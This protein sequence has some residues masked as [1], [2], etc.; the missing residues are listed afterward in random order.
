MESGCIDPYFLKLSTSWRWVVSFTPRPLY[1]RGR[2]PRYP[3]DKR[4]GGPQSRSGRRGDPARGQS[5][6]W[7][8]YPG[9]HN[10]LQYEIILHFVHRL[11]FCV[12]IFLMLYRLYRINRLVLAMETWSAFCATFRH[13]SLRVK[14]LR[15][16]SGIVWHNYL[17]SGEF[18]L[19]EE[20]CASFSTGTT[21]PLHTGNLGVGCPPVTITSEFFADDPKTRAILV[22]WTE[23]VNVQCRGIRNVQFV[24]LCH[25]KWEFLAKFCK[26]MFHWLCSL[27][28]FWRLKLAREC[29]GKEPDVRVRNAKLFIKKLFQFTVLFRVDSDCV[30]IN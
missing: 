1:L 15:C 13:T 22:L 21:N 30:Y 23:S 16:H 7:L 9:S 24:L 2:S 3:L 14:V 25:I 6:Y 5:V 17:I 26:T 12:L 11:Y 18:T 4:L 27:S 20:E 8:C 10:T 29:F 19:D 28:I